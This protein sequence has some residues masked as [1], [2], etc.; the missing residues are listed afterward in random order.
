MK[1]KKELS[2]ILVAIGRNVKRLRLEKGL[3]Q[4]DLAF[5]CDM[6]KSTVSNIERFNLDNITI[7][8]LVKMCLILECNLIE[9]FK[10]L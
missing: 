7:G 4:Q 10:I 6:D 3:T 1:Y 9:L 5:E 2:C 8:T